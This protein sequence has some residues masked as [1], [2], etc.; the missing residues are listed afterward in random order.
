MCVIRYIY[1]ISICALYVYL[2]HGKGPEKE[3]GPTLTKYIYSNT[4]SISKSL[5]QK[6]RKRG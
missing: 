3:K 2:G 4:I 5:E 1:H 6:L